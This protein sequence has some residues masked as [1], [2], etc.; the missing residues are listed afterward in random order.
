MTAAPPPAAP[1]DAAA[2]E[3]HVRKVGSLVVHGTIH[4]RHLAG[5]IPALEQPGPP[6]HACR[7]ILHRAFTRLQLRYQQD[8]PGLPAPA[9]VI[10]AADAAFEEMATRCP[11]LAERLMDLALNLGHTDPTAWHVVTGRLVPSRRLLDFGAAWSARARALS[12]ASFF[13]H[14]HLGV[15]HTLLR[16]EEA[17]YR[18]FLAARQARPPDDLLP[19]YYAAL[20]SLCAPILAAEE[21]LAWRRPAAF[22]DWFPMAADAAILRPPPPGEGLLYLCG[23]DS[24]YATAFAP[25]VLAAL[26]RHGGRRLHLHLVDPTPGCLE[27]LDRLAREGE[28]VGVAL[29]ATAEYR[30]AVADLRAYY[31]VSRFFAQRWLQA[32]GLGRVL[33]ADID[34]VPCDDL[35]KLDHATAGQDL[36]LLRGRLP[37]FRFPWAG[38]RAGALL[39]GPAPGAGTFLQLLC[40]TIEREFDRQATGLWGIDQNALF[41]AA[42]YLDALSHGLRIGNLRE[43]FPNLIQGIADKRAKLAAL[44]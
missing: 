29:S 28:A 44:P 39:A 42:N 31:S 5:C 33:L 36:A 43:A 25:E 20:R 24:R 22:R 13:R 6:G 19:S 38:V 9:T 41:V 21:E 7:V 14:V 26:A 11:F 30:P 2:T 23:A 40:R 10:A 37:L 8:E 1:A 3:R 27:L 34:M 35:R 18:H 16:N 12:P 15:R 17:A 4:R 32:E